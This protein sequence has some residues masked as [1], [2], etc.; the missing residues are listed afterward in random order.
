MIH[1]NSLDKYILI[2]KIYFIEVILENALMWQH[3]FEK[4]TQLKP[5]QIWPI[6]ADVA[7]WAKVDHNIDFIKVEGTPR[8]GTK[9]VLKPKGGPKLKFTI[10][11][12]VPPTTYSDICKMPF[13]T[14]KTLHTLIP[15]EKTTIRVD[16][17]ISGPL[18]RLW[19]LVVGR[20]HAEGLPE[21]TERILM[22]AGHLSNSGN[23]S[24]G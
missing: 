1:H 23:N 12:F 22:A 15:G 18:S 4:S 8:A 7:N 11:D 6:L 16:I 13:A 24:D 9:F 17:L 14:M 10:G 19:G 5:N 20:K 2:I 3:R 21:Q